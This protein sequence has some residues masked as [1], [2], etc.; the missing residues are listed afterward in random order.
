MTKLGDMPAFPRDHVMGANGETVIYPENGMTYRQ[1]LV[2]RLAPAVLETALPHGA[3]VDA[4]IVAHGA[5]LLA[6]AIIAELERP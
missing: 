2:G 5:V 6:D 4:K 3:Q 1:W